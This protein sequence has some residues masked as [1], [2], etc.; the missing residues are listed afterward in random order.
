MKINNEGK[1][2]YHSLIWDEGLNLVFRQYDF[3][4]SVEEERVLSRMPPNPP[5][6]FNPM[7]PFYWSTNK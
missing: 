4:G 5:E 7:I 1:I 6:K 2:A 3:D